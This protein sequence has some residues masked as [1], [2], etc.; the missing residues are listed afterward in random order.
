M[1]GIIVWIETKN[2]QIKKTAKEAAAVAAK[3]A[4]AKNLSRAA[5][6][7]NNEQLAD[8]VKK[9]GFEKI[10]HVVDEQLE[11]Y[12]GE[13]YGTTL[14]AAADE[15]GA[16]HVV[17]GGSALGRDLAA[18]VAAKKDA[19]LALDVVEIDFQSEPFK[20]VK[21]VYSGKLLAEMEM[22]GDVK[23]IAVRPNVFEI[24]AE[25]EGNG[26]TVKFTAGEL[27]I[28]ARVV[29][30]V[31]AAQ[32]ILDVTEADIICSGGR[33]V[34]GPEGFKVIEDLAKTLG[35]AVGASRVAVDE[36]WI[37]YKHQVGQ[38]GK[39]VSPV[40]YIACGISG[41]IQHFAGM[42]S[43]KFIIA[44]NKDPECPMMEKADFAI[45]GD[46]FE[47]VPV[48]KEELSKVINK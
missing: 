6:L 3:I 22:N 16:D 1:A 18:T 31:Q 32:E 27:N 29:K 4:A 38:T 40:L 46:L 21:P 19:A 43:A 44:V 7:I 34:G 41:A 23:V 39:V 14:A 11:N 17:I 15:F 2:G 24:D 20:I 10:Y 48:L 26:E 36:G 25:S 47:V 8:D 45:E 33:G 28:R 9:L 42:G 5:L 35:G 13:G 12:S 30:A 37:P